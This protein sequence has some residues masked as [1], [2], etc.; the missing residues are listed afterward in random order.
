MRKP[1]FQFLFELDQRFGFSRFF[2]PE[3]GLHLLYFFYQKAMIAKRDKLRELSSTQIV[4]VP[5]ARSRTVEPPILHGK[6]FFDFFSQPIIFKRG[7]CVHS[8]IADEGEIAEVLLCF[9]NG[10]VVE[11][12]LQLSPAPFPGT[13]Q[14]L[15]YF[16]LRRFRELGFSFF[17]LRL[18]FKQALAKG[19][20]FLASLSGE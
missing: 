5:C 16:L 10:F 3:L 2:L 9:G 14:V 6:E 8:L 17:Y 11:S 7:K 20:F 18:Q 15:V 19:E 4:R 12:Y 13:D 1:V